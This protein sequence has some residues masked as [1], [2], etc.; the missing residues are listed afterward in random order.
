MRCVKSY[1][2]V[3]N[4]YKLSTEKVNKNEEKTDQV[5]ASMPRGV[6]LLKFRARL[7][8]HVFVTTTMCSYTIL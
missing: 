8:L 6:K 2:I 7:A 1:K 5:Q 4:S 3:P